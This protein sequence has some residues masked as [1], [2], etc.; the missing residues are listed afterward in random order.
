MLTNPPDSPVATKNCRKYTNLAFPPRPKLYI[1]VSFCNIIYLLVWSPCNCTMQ[2]QHNS[3]QVACCLRGHYSE[4]TTM[5]LP[6]HSSILYPC[7]WLKDRTWRNSYLV[8]C[9]TEFPLCGYCSVGHWYPSTR[10]QY[11]N[12][13]HHLLNTSHQENLKTLN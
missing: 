6:Q 8:C 4:T 2:N 10:L 9:D 5:T 12:T 7:S 3:S 1:S 13:E 11:H